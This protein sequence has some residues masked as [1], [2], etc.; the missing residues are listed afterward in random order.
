LPRGR[1]AGTIVGM[2][3]IPIGGAAAALPGPGVMTLRREGTQAK[4]LK[5]G[6]R[7]NNAYRDSYLGKSC[8]VCEGTVAASNKLREKPSSP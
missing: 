6:V 5:A 8:A 2:I 1:A 3:A 4:A 7:F